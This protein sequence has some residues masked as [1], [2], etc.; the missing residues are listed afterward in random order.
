MFKQSLNS[1]LELRDL[2]SRY[3]HRCRKPNSVSR[4]SD[5]SLYMEDPPSLDRLSESL[6][7]C[8]LEHFIFQIIPHVLRFEMY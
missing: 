3:D 4:V 2:K 7:T 6:V 8:I 1:L 5:Q